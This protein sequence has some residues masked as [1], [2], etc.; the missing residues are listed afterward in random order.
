MKVG[1]P[2]GTECDFYTR[3]CPVYMKK[4]IEAFVRG[5]D[6]TKKVE[7]SAVAM[8][9]SLGQKRKKGRPALAKPA[10]LRQ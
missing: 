6:S 1:H 2:Y 3:N 5:I 9:T 10:L 8:N 7:L 4:K